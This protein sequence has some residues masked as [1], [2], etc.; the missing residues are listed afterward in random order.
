MPRIT[1]RDTE[2][3]EAVREKL[4]QKVTIIE[5]VRRRRETWFG[6]ARNKDG[7]RLPVRVMHCQVEGT[8]QS[9]T[10]Q[11][12]DRQHQGG[13]GSMQLGH[14]KSAGADRR[15]QEMDSHRLNLIM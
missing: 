12:V 7:N 1:R 5:R 4:E 15:P 6:A 14:G 13:P 2:R 11:K 9:K 10:T 3:N 8:E